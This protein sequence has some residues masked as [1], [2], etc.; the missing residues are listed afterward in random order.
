MATNAETFE[1]LQ[2]TLYY[3]HLHFPDA[4]IVVYDL[5]LTDEMREKVSLLRLKSLF[6]V[7]FIKIVS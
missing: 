7:F 4:S 5:G 1:H 3:V 2:A 6:N